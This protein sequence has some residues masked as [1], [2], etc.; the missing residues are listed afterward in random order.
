MLLFIPLSM[1]MSDQIDIKD[2]HLEQEVYDVAMTIF[3]DKSMA[4]EVAHNFHNS[5]L[6]LIGE[7]R[8]EASVNNS[9]EVFA[10]TG[11]INGVVAGL[12]QKIMAAYSD[13]TMFKMYVPTGVSNGAVVVTVK[14]NK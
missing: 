10:K 3:H 9:L 11:K 7:G 13:D 14:Y 8:L 2:L 1:M 12:D 5:G 4:K 6:S